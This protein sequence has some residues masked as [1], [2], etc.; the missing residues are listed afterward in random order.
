M[1]ATQA[2]KFFAGITV[3]LSTFLFLFIISEYKSFSSEARY[4]FNPNSNFK[5]TVVQQTGRAVTPPRNIIEG[6]FDVE[7]EGDIKDQ[8]EENGGIVVRHY[9]AI[10]SD[11]IKESG[12]YPTL[13]LQVF[14]NEQK[15]WVVTK[16]TKISKADGTVYF[17]LKTEKS[18]NFIPN[19]YYTGTYQL[20]FD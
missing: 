15:S 3:M 13:K 10:H 2:L 8:T 6:F 11:R 17:L 20:I 14:N 18:N 12:D 7:R 9:R 19:D 16:I 4:V 1:K 5:T